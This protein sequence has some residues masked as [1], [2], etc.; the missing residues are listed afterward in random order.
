VINRCNSGTWDPI[1]ASYYCAQQCLERA[2]SVALRLPLGISRPGRS[3]R[4]HLGAQS[5]PTSPDLEESSRVNTRF[6]WAFLHV[7]QLTAAGGVP[8]AGQ[9]PPWLPAAHQ[10]PAPG[11]SSAGMGLRSRISPC[12]TP[13]TTDTRKRAQRHA[14]HANPCKQRRSSHHMTRTRA[15]TSRARTH[16]TARGSDGPG[17]HAFSLAPGKT[18]TRSPFSWAS[19]II[20]TPSQFF[21]FSGITHPVS[22][23]SLIFDTG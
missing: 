5:A 23:L 14:G 12:R 10:V 13:R 22:G 6:H 3:A 18:G 16:L 2:S 15:R 19:E 9:T 17:K 8:A 1:K 4:R 21:I 7:A 20:K 11:I